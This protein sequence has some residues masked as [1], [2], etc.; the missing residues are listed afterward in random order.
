MRREIKGVCQRAVCGRVYQCVSGCME[1]IAAFGRVVQSPYTSATDSIY[2][3]NQL[4]ICLWCGK[5]DS[6]MIPMETLADLGTC[7]YEIRDGTKAV[8]HTD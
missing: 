5:I 3:C 2:V 8:G 7:V 4:C 6:S 1:L